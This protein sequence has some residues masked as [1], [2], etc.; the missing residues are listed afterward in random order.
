MSHTV[1]KGKGKTPHPTLISYRRLLSTLFSP[2]PYVVFFYLYL[3]HTNSK[4][5]M[6]LSLRA[7]TLLPCSMSAFFIWYPRAFSRSYLAW[8]GGLLPLSLSYRHLS[9]NHGYSDGVQGVTG[10]DMSPRPTMLQVTMLHFMRGHKVVMGS[11]SVNG[12]LC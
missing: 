2:V 7:S 8:C 12:R 3:S 1:G 10:V 5:L 6:F 9:D 11:I 4:G